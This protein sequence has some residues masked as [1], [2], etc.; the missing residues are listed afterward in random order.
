[1]TLK[2][3]FVHRNVEVEMAKRKRERVAKGVN[4]FPE[5]KIY[6]VHVSK[7]HP[8]LR[9][10]RSLRRLKDYDGREITSLAQ[11]QA[12]L[13]HMKRELEERVLN[14]PHPFW[15]E[16]VK[17]FSDNMRNNGYMIET[18]RNYESSLAKHTFKRWDKKKVNEITSSMIIDLF[19]ENLQW[20]DHHKKAMRKHVR[21]VLEYAVEKDYLNKN[22]MPKIRCKA[23]QKLKTVLTES[24]I[25]RLLAKS[26]EHDFELKEHVFMSV[27]LGCRPGELRFLKWSSIDFENKLI[28]I[29]GSTTR[30][31]L[32]KSTKTG[33]DRVLPM[34]KSMETFLRRLKL[35]THKDQYVL[36]LVPTWVKH[37][38]SREFKKFLQKIGLPI[39][40]YYDLRASWCTLL[41][42]KGI[43]TAKVML[44]G[45]WKK[46]STM[47]YYLRM[48]GIHV[49]DGLDS[50][51]HLEF[52]K[53]EAEII[54]MREAGHLGVVS[55]K[56]V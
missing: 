12:I 55:L 16:V 7:R 14:N 45:G 23:A 41:L 39:I 5:L 8:I 38:Q 43:P 35:T 46:I 10:S 30:S 54:P 44:L 2:S 19:D 52:D 6:E 13:P 20:S 26:I 34:T 42:A 9:Q 4:Y 49:K 18:V 50:I 28:Y 1:M 56:K 36:P 31:G 37:E 27:R 24:Q 15:V 48:A 29:K 25:Q 32:E 53:I 21:A 40:R 11:A 51:D 17:N 22:P 47:D 3:F 33:E